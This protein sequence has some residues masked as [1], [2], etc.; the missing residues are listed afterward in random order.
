MSRLQAGVKINWVQVDSKTGRDSNTHTHTHT[1]TCRNK[2]E[3]A[4]H[5]LE[6]CFYSIVT[7]FNPCV[8]LGSF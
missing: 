4:V 2:P 7:L 5:H 1:H 3:T 8:A 6:P